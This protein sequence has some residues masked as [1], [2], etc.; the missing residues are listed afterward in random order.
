MI[1]PKAATPYGAAMGE[2]SPEWLA[3]REPA[4][5]AARNQDVLAGLAHAFK[6]HDAL[7]ICDM[8]AGTGASVRAFADLL[9]HRQ[10]WILVDHDQRNLTGALT[11]LRNWADRGDDAII[12]RGERRIGLRTLQQDFARDPAPWPA[13]TGLVTASALLDL[14]STAWIDA[15]VA[16][17]VERKLPALITLTVDGV[18][19][20]DP[21][22]ALDEQVFAAFRSHQSGDKGFGPSAGAG[23]A[24]YLERALAKAGYTIECGD[25]PW[26]ID[27]GSPVLMRELLAGIA[28]AARETGHVAA[29]DQWLS[30]RIA[31][32]ARLTIG[33]RDVF[34]YL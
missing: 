34:A 7:V 33:H 22:H 31:N 29:V 12:Y 32:T 10:D 2:F 3:L 16:K 1:A 27:Q 14:P 6:D 28:G 13:D 23:A 25:S 4:D 15:F 18:M 30:D 17:L 20:A 8:G 26:V 5:Q 19:A 11:A 21:P 9:P 24:V